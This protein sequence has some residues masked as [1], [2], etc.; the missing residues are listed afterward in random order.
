M[1]LFNPIAY[2]T[3]YRRS[4]TNRKNSECYIENGDI[5]IIKKTSTCITT[6][7]QGQFTKGRYTNKTVNYYQWQLINQHYLQLSHLRNPDQTAELLTTFILTNDSKRITNLNTYNCAQDS[8][9][10]HLAYHNDKLILVW[11]IKGPKKNLL[12]ES[13]YFSHKKKL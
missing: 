8:Y 4:I 7:E 6:K 12:I 2:Y 10:A 13:T 1:K 9:T 11:D 5:I 3:H